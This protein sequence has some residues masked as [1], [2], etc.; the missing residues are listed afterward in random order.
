MQTVRVILVREGT[1]DPPVTTPDE[2]VD[3]LRERLQDL[4]R[5][6]FV[7]L[8]L[9]ARH[10]PTGLDTVSI[11]TLSAS[12]AHPREVFKAAILASAGAILLAHN[13]PSGDVTPSK[14]D[15]DLTRR[16]VEAGRIIGIE[17][18]D[19]II[20]GDGHHLSFRERGLI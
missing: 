16:M 3:L 19:H 11:G 10:A 12:L 15:A 8:H 20:I 4:D 14:D 6:H 5:E 2:V 1:P 9:D 18:I 13:H 7:V 17:V